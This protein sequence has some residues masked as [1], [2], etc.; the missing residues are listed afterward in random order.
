M[1][2]FQ[3]LKFDILEEVIVSECSVFEKAK[4]ENNVPG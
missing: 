4:F 1:T 3:E 2:I